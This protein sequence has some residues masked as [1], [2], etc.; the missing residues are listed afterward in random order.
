MSMACEIWCSMKEWCNNEDVAI[1]PPVRMEGVRWQESTNVEV[2]RGT[3]SVQM[4]WKPMNAMR[5][6]G[7]WGWGGGGR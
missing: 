2:C 4:K 3:Q 5:G 6:R 1:P 7:R